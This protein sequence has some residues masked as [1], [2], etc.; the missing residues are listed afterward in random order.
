MLQEYN[1]LSL[2]KQ[3]AAKTSV[4]RPQVAVL[5]SEVKDEPMAPVMPDA[6]FYQV[7][8]RQFI[9]RAVW[10]AAQ[11]AQAEA[12]DTKARSKRPDSRIFGEQF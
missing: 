5:R 9:T 3:D 6:D 7:R 12:L 10:Q 8:Q 1:T 11:D 4:E 2:S